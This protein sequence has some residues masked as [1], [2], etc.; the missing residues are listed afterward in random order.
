M[1]KYFSCILPNK[2]SKI[3]K[4]P[5]KGLIYLIVRHEPFYKLSQYWI[6]NVC[7]HNICHNNLRYIVHQKLDGIVILWQTPLKYIFLLPLTQEISHASN[8]NIKRLLPSLFKSII[9]NLVFFDVEQEWYKQILP[10]ITIFEYV[11]YFWL[12]LTRHKKCEY[13]SIYYMIQMSWN[14]IFILPVF[15]QLPRFR[16]CL[17]F[18]YVSHVWPWHILYKYAPFL[19]TYT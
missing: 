3:C 5:Q 19:V 2:W 11:E 9:G 17:T 12:H 16:I 4:S 10:K 18:Y 6:E 8:D 13:G 7:L 15:C 1:Y 14:S